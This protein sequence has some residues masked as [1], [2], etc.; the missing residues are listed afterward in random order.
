MSRKFLLKTG[1][2]SEC[3]VT[4]TRLEPTTIYFV[5]KQVRSISLLISDITPVLSKALLGIQAITECRFTLNM[6]VT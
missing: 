2:I 5:Y 4:V 6:Y 1:A 3:L